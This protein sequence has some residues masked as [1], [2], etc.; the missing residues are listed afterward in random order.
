MPGY[1]NDFIQKIGSFATT[2]NLDNLLRWS[3]QRLV[4]PVYH[5][6]TDDNVPHIQHLYPVKNI[7]Q[8][9]IDL[10]F[11]LKYF[12]PIDLASLIQ[13]VE[14]SKQLSKP[15][16]HLTFDDGLQEFASTI[17]PILKQKGIPATNFLNTAFIDNR[18]LFFRYKVSLIIDQLSL[19]ETPLQKQIK[20]DFFESSSK[21]VS[22]SDLLLRLEYTDLVLID[23]IAEELKIDFTDYL[24]GHQPYLTSMQ[25]SHLIEEGF[26][27]GGHSIDHPLLGKLPLDEQIRQTIESVES[28]SHQFNLPWKT[29]AFPFTD[30]GISMHYFDH[31]YGDDRHLDLSFG[32]AG[33]KQDIYARHLQ[34]IPMEMG[35]LPA[36]KIIHGELLYFLMKRPF[37]K[38]YIVRK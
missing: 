1:R 13:H 25:I 22:L 10:E 28:V 5:L 15:S 9:Q 6:A 7:D 8:F 14:G 12:E 24:K 32:S 11:L 26:T 4:L 18:D 21:E 36:D 2:I 33:L 19:S 23:Q 38:N 20:K 3:D 30:Y 37:G 27:F 17:S 35:Y 29:F 31:F 16:F 34:R